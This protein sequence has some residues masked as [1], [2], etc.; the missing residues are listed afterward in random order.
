[1]KPKSNRFGGMRDFVFSRG[2]IRDLSRKQGREGGISVANG[3]GICALLGLG[4]EIG[5]GNRGGYG[6]PIPT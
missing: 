1:M 2:D 5:K 4:C 6:S 3:T